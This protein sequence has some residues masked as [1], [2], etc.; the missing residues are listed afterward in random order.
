M[1]IKKITAFVLVMAL[2]M[3]PCTAHAAQR[4][5]LKVRYMDDAA[6]AALPTAREEA[7]NILVTAVPAD[8]IQY[9]TDHHGTI[10]IGS[11]DGSGGQTMLA[12]D[13]KMKPQI[14]DVVYK[15]Y[16][17]DM[18]VNAKDMAYGF[19]DD[20][21]IHEFGHVFDARYGITRNPAYDAVIAAEI[22]AIT[23]ANLGIITDP[24]H[25]ATTPE[26]FAQVY[27]AYRGGKNIVGGEATLNAAPQTVQIIKAFEGRSN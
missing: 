27:A 20:Y 21:L 14:P 15:D 12:I 25:Y 19:L 5:Q 22:P 4:V 18:Y 13:E 11:W 6:S 2:A 7:A 23:Q 1:R 16:P 10:Y 3:A 17:L 26:A 9:F 8:M 24:M